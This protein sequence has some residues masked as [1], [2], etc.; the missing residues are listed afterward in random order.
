M[1]TFWQLNNRQKYGNFVTQMDSLWYCYH[2]LSLY[3]KNYI[4]SKTKC[5]LQTM[6]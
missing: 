3:Q 5:F 2:L 6:F 4:Q 1:A